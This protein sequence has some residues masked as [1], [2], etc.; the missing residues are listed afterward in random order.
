MSDD[1]VIIRSARRTR[2]NGNVH[3]EICQKDQ[4]NSE[5]RFREYQGK[6]F[7]ILSV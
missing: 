1:Q 6:I 5:I 4:V 2:R 7:Q 3:E